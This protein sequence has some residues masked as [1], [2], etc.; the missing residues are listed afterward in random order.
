[1]NTP[2]PRLT[3]YLQ[4]WFT[5]STQEK[6]KSGVSVTL[7]FPE[8]LALFNA[9]QLNSLQK[10]I[11]A[12]RLRYTQS[13]DNELALVLTWRSYSART[14]NVFSKDTATVCSRRKSK[15]ISLPKKG[16]TLRLSHCAAISAS[17]TGRTLSD[18]T[19][20]KISASSKGQPKAAWSP[21]RKAARSEQRKA[22]EAAKRGAPL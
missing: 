12:N 9:R 18:E 22:Q 19:K 10:S 13:E 21:A 11:D 4:S 16:E 5:T 3:A 20:D 15:Q 1:M 7:T 6:R 2:S 14:S 8:F 17:L